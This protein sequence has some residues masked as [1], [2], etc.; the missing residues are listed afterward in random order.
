MLILF[1]IKNNFLFFFVNFNNFEMKANRMNGFA[2]K[3]DWRIFSPNN[4]NIIVK[5]KTD[6]KA[7]EHSPE[8]GN[9]IILSSF[10]Y[11][12]HRIRFNGI[13]E[14]M[15]LYFSNLYFIYSIYFENVF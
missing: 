14:L 7:H 9:G 10:V 5:L 1:H 11:I 4:F 13:G 8:S 15:A 6:D 2:K 3:W 12:M